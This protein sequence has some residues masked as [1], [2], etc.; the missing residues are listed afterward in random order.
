MQ[1]EHGARRDA[2]ALEQVVDVL[3]DLDELWVL[4]QC[5]VRRVRLRARELRA[6]PVVPLDDARGVVEEAADGREL[7]RV[8]LRSER[9][10]FV[11]A[12]MAMPD[13]ALRPAPEKTAVRR[14]AARARR[15]A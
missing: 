11:A 15:A 1:V 8:E 12:E 5:D 9:V 2:G 13:S 6:A 3:R 4:G 7:Q 14:A 10:R